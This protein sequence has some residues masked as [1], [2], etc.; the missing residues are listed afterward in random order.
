MTSRIK[1]IFFKPEAKVFEH[2]NI[3][4]SQIS[5]MN[6]SSWFMS[7]PS[8]EETVV[9]Y[10]STCILLLCLAFLLLRVRFYMLSLPSQASA[11]GRYCV[12]DKQCL[13]NGL[14][15]APDHYLPFCWCKALSW[16]SQWCSRY[17]DTDNAVSIT[18]IMF[19]AR[20]SHQC[21]R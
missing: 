3:F 13:L 14:I 10:N 7:H 17:L 11:V 1:F 2:S 4:Y 21:G 6:S 12:I 5:F 19:M 9:T 15:C 8:S 20:Y 18:Y 16:E